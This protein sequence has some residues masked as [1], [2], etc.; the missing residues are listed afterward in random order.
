[1]CINFWPG[2]AINFFVRGANIIKEKL[3][4]SK[5]QGD[6]VLKEKIRYIFNREATFGHFYV[7]NLHLTTTNL[8]FLFP[9]RIYATGNY[10]L[11]DIG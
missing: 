7:I 6:L 1:M 5:N 10:F 2:K 11:I 3:E 9:W 8:Q 4:I